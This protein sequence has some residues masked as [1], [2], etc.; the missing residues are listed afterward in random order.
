MKRIL[1]FC[2]FAGMIASSEIRL[3]MRPSVA[4]IPLT[5]SFAI[6]EAMA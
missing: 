1:V 6:C 4:T 2:L 3:I 5:K